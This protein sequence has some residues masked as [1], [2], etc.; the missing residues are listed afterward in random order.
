MALWLPSEAR[1]KVHSNP[2]AV[3]LREFQSGAERGAHT[4]PSRAAAGAAAPVVIGSSALP[5]TPP[6][7]YK[8][9]GSMLLRMRWGQGCGA[10]LQ[11]GVDTDTPGD[12][13]VSGCEGG[14]WGMGCA[15]N[16]L[17]VV[18]AMLLQSCAAMCSIHI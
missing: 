8:H 11:G 15:D 14:A 16:G 4:R 1:R 6:R 3:C 17:H 5:N 18:H 7:C 13:A 2:S 12:C 9:S 10:L